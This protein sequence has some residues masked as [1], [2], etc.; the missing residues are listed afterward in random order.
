MKPVKREIF[1]LATEAIKEN[2]KDKKLEAILEGVDVT[3]LELI[4]I[5]LVL[6]KTHSNSDL[7]TYKVLRHEIQLEDKIFRLDI[8]VNNEFAGVK[9]EGRYSVFYDS[10]NGIDVKDIYP[11]E[12]G[13][14]EVVAAMLDEID[15]PNA[16]SSTKIYEFMKEEAENQ[17]IL[18]SEMYVSK[19]PG[20]KQI[21]PAN[22]DME[23][24]ILKFENDM[25]IEVALYDLE[26]GIRKIQQ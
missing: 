26:R 16:I 2:F 21:L 19:I 9:V 4:D 13:I 5:Q 3:Q 15:Y 24:V 22:Y 14:E 6:V 11:G 7:N 18:L 20:V 23:S 1:N 10:F 17:A 12:E 8:E 25:E